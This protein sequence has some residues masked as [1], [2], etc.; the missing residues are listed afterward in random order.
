MEQH[1]QWLM[2]LKMATKIW[3][4]ML[5][6]D[7]DPNFAEV[8]KKYEAEVNAAGKSEKPKEPKKKAKK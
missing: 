2:Q 1:Q 7:D 3:K 8:S 5:T 6:G 4:N